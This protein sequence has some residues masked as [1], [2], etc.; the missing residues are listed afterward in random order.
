MLRLFR[1]TAVG[2]RIGGGFNVIMSR[3]TGPKSKLCRMEGT[4]VY[5]RGGRCESGKCSLNRKPQAPGMHGNSKRRVSN[6]GVQLREK[7]KIK[8]SYGLM[9][10]N[11]RHYFEEAVRKQGVTGEI[12][13]QLLERRLDNVVYRLGLAVSRPAA[14][15]LVTEGKVTVNGKKNTYPSYSVRLKDSVSTLMPF[16]APDGYKFPL[17]LEFN[18]ASKSGS[19]AALPSRD[20][21]D[22][23]FNEQFVVEYYSR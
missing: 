9:E 7:Q 19:V 22:Q 10:K 3:Y 13:L 12:M 6:F 8:R 20:Q 15:K 18:K 21:I 23:S 11:F 2:P 14:R 1:T 4:H 16:V 5:Q 17:W